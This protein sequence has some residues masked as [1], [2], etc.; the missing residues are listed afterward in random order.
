MLVAFRRY[1]CTG[2]EARVVVDGVAYAPHLPIDVAGWGVDWYG[3]SV[4][5][6]WGP[7][8]A[9]L[10]G[11]RAAFQDLNVK[12]PPPPPP[13]PPRPLPPSHLSPSSVL[14]FLCGTFPCLLLS[15]LFSRTLSLGFIFCVLQ[16]CLSSFRFTACSA[17]GD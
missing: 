8:M 9:A 3:F 14:F 7:H 2:G 12:S 11:T 17:I 1:L 6:T 16:H 15:I 4:Y 10:Y 5:K 13:R